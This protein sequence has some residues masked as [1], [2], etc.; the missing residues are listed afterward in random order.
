MRAFGGLSGV[1]RGGSHP[2][3]WQTPPG[4]GPRAIGRGPGYPIRSIFRDN[5]LQGRAVY[6]VTVKIFDWDLYVNQIFFCLFSFFL[7]HFRGG[8]FFGEI[9]KMAVD[10]GGG[11]PLNNL[12]P[13]RLEIWPWGL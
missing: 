1:W 5:P 9:I 6:I 13:A 2:K 11:T 7:G 3:W 12:R 10:H 8:H 4:P